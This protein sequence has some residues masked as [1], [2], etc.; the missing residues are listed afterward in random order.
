MALISCP[1]CKKEIS[2][3]AHS[4][5]FCGFPLDEYFQELKEEE[6]EKR[7]KEEEALQQEELEKRREV[8]QESTRFCI[9]GRE[10][11]FDVNKKICALIG[12]EFQ[13]M[14]DKAE[15]AARDGMRYNSPSECDE[16]Q[17]RKLAT[18]LTKSVF[19]PLATHTVELYKDYS[20]FNTDVSMFEKD[21]TEFVK[22]D[23]T[24]LF[25]ILIEAYHIAK[26]ETDLD[27]INA[28]EQ[29]THD[30]EAA[31][32]PWAPVEAVYTDASLGGVIRGS[33]KANMINAITTGLTMGSVE[34][35]K[36]KART[37]YEETLNEISDFIDRKV[38]EQLLTQVDAIYSNYLMYLLS[39][40]EAEGS[41]FHTQKYPKKKYDYENYEIYM[42]ASADHNNRERKTQF[43]NYIGYNPANPHI[44]H[45][46]VLTVEMQENEWNEI[47]RLI[48]YLG[49][50]DAVKKVMEPLETDAVS[51]IQLFCE[52]A[53]ISA[54]LKE[55]S[56]DSRTAGDVTYD[57]VE[58]A[59]KKEKQYRMERK[60]FLPLLEYFD[61][62]EYFFDETEDT[63]RPIDSLNKYIKKAQEFLSYDKPEESSL[64]QRYQL[65]APVLYEIQTPFFMRIKEVI[66]GYYDAC[67][68]YMNIKTKEYNDFWDNVVIKWYTYKNAEEVKNELIKSNPKLGD[69]FSANEIPLVSLYYREVIVTTR[70]FYLALSNHDR[71]IIR[72]SL[73]DVHSIQLIAPWL[74]TKWRCNI[75]LGEKGC[76]ELLDDKDRIDNMGHRYDLVL[77][78]AKDLET[79]FKDGRIV[80]EETRECTGCGNLIPKT[81]QFCTICGSVKDSGAHKQAID[82]GRYKSAPQEEKNTIE[83]TTCGKR[84]PQSARF[85]TFCGNVNDPKRRDETSEKKEAEPSSEE[86]GDTVKCKECNK[87]IPKVA[88]FCTFCGALNN[89]G[90]SQI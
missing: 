36:K 73:E 38:Y 16:S 61:E 35:Q 75:D 81:A 53:D 8:F 56:K 77:E 49:I 88:K 72:F 74:D 43:C 84:I 86:K 27:S 51:P 50:T 3:R 9:F 28:Y 87:A 33:V 20:S 5:P 48:D 29:Y 76:Y 31:G 70:A 23:F 82:D 19:E 59:E 4:C 65:I 64:Q 46:A 1:E 6:E 58:G 24:S 39:Y 7:I 12:A 41:L 21:F 47:R 2:D 42:W 22:R 62:H 25:E 55:L 18:Q 57:S 44:Y 32:E 66:A 30:L 71:N 17:L 85:C 14:K 10:Y 52:D 26:G 60:R 45:V 80:L 90:I 68:T 83:C 89:I 79:L 54:V 11:I 13:L 63:F 15:S 69:Y 34:R 37:R 67:S 40:L 78:F